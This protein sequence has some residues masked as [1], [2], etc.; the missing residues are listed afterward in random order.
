M[1]NLTDK[2]SQILTLLKGNTTELSDRLEECVVIARGRGGDLSYEEGAK[3]LLSMAV[4]RVL[5]SSADLRKRQTDG[6]PLR[7]Q[8]EQVRV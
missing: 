4:C 5:A 7:N 3:P 6:F 1:G 2:N 8:Y